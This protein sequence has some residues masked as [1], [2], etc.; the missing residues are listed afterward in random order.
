[1]KPI[2]TAI[3]TASYACLAFLHVSCVREDTGDCIQYVLDMQAVDSEGND[4][5]ATDALQKVEVYLFNEKGFIRKIP[6]DISSDLI[7]R[8]DKNERLTLVVWGNIKKDTLI[9]PDIPIGTTI[10]EARFRLREDTEGSHLPITDIFYCKKEVN[11]ATTRSRQ[12]EYLTL[13]MERMSASLNIR[14]NYLTKHCPYNGKPYTLIVRGTGTE[15]NFTGKITGKSAGYK[16][17]SYTDK[18]GDVYT[19]PFRIFPTAQEEYIEIDIYR[20]HEIIY[21]I[22]QDNSFKKLHAP[23]GKQTDINIDFHYTPPLITMDVLPWE[24]IH[25][26]TEL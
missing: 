1:M 16:P 24:N 5:T 20:E 4:L 26:D 10:E 3:L 15:V 8:D 21:T 17:I 12:V 11:N 23:A 7:F 13:V 25:Q 2:R 6:T 18:Q 14:T 19:L 9:A 22:T